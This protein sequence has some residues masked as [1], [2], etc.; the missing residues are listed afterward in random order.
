MNSLNEHVFKHSGIERMEKAF[1]IAYKILKSILY[2]LP[3]I[4]KCSQHF[5]ILIKKWTT[6]NQFSFQQRWK[7]NRNILARNKPVTKFERVK[8]YNILLYGTFDLKIR[9]LR[10]IL[11]PQYF[12]TNAAT[13]GA[14]FCTRYSEKERN[15]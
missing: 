2:I 3:N 1:I 7:L 5:F 13:F 4:P 12:P 8:F 15:L 9:L 6:F 10:A 11:G 14:Q